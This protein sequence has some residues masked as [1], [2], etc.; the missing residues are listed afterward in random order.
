[1]FTNLKHALALGYGTYKMDILCG[2]LW[3]IMMLFLIEF[4]KQGGCYKHK[5]KSMYEY[6]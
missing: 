5:P 3:I 4:N 1:M 6:I 2:L